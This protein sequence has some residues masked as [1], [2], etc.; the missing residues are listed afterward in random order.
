MN[1]STFSIHIQNFIEIT[2]RYTVQ[3]KTDMVFIHSKSQQCLR[4][5]IHLYHER[6]PNRVCPSLH[7]RSAITKQSRQTG[8]GAAKKHNRTQTVTGKQNA[9]AVVAAVTRE[10]HLSTRQLERETGISRRSIL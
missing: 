4:R 6:F 10:P 5:A 7:T 2:M 3:E 1:W 9:V 8:K